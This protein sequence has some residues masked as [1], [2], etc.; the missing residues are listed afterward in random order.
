MHD[1][2]GIERATLAAM[3]PEDSEEL[4]GW[5]VALDHGTVGRAH[6]A[7]PL[8]HAAPEARAVALV[9]QR[10][11]RFGTPAVFRLPEVAAFDALRAD[12]EARGY[13]PSKTT[14]VQVARV[15]DMPLP[16]DA[17]VRL[18]ATPAASF[19]N[20]F[21]GEGFDPVD[22]ASRLAILGRARDSAFAS[23]ERDGATVAVGSACFSQGW[24]GIHG[25]RTLPVQRKQGSAGRILAAFAQEAR[26][27]GLQQAFLQVEEGNA[28]ARSLYA[29][30][31]FATA[32]AY[33]YWKQ[34]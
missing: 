3:P 20:V 33:R 6:S 9:E 26:A 13:R 31:G 29:R 16:T 28:V 21:L 5:L 10:Y 11:A 1:I 12:L 14:L 8:A 19:G 15:Q 27:R 22:G 24:C 18:S 23:I 7:A 25:M 30:L 4:A 2:A 32:W 17:V 34:A